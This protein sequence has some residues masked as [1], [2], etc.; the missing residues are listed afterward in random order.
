MIQNYVTKKLSNL[1]SKMRSIHFL[2]VKLNLLFSCRRDNDT[3]Y[4]STNNLPL[5]A[6]KD[7]LLIID[8]SIVL[9]IDVLFGFN[10]VCC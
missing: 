6:L 3:I 1:N 7:V 4:Y 10:T 9:I 5:I 8:V 2:C